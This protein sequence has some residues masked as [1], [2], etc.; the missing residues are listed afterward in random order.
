MP[1]VGSKVWNDGF[2]YKGVYVRVLPYED[3]KFIRN[4]IK[5]LRFV[6]TELLELKTLAKG[7]SKT[8]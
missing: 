5:A 8:L 7:N 2:E 3:A 4:E 1:K 6:Q